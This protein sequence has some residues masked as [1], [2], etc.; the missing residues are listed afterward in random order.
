MTITSI[1]DYP[2]S[3]R[4]PRF[5]AFLGAIPQGRGQIIRFGRKYTIITWILCLFIFDA[6]CLPRLQRYTESFQKIVAFARLFTFN[7]NCI[8]TNVSWPRLFKKRHH[9]LF[10]VQQKHMEHLLAFEIKSHLKWLAHQ[11]F[12]YRL[13]TV[14][15]KCFW[16]APPVE[17][18]H[19]VFFYFWCDSGVCW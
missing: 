14:D 7:T 9:N 3:S 5:L 15:H 12:H 6:N 2:N 13:W 17:F 11:F 16:S 18:V 4:L 1:H 10:D 19:D 8:W